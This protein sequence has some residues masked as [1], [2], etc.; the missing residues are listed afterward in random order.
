MYYMGVDMLINLSDVFTSEGKT[1]TDTVE[2]EMKEFSSRLG[3]FSL[4][5]KEPASFVFTNCG[6]NKVK[7]EGGVKLTFD[8]V[9]DRCLTAVPTVLELQ[10]DR[11][12]TSPEYVSADE[13]EDDDTDVMEGY[14]LDVETFVYH[15][16]LTNW[17][18]KILCKE[19]CKGTCPVCGQ[20][21]NDGECGCDTFVPDPRM[22]VL[23]DIFNANKEV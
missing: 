8:T 3:R 6:E 19:D 1:K 18:L 9:C 13:D 14:Q 2:I 23:K 11:T 5:G 22:A 16:I 15:E 4:I 21:L 7:V 12:F 10:F 17:P 20:N